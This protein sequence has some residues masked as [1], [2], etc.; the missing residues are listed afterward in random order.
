MSY[1]DW[2]IRRAAPEKG[3]SSRTLIPDFDALSRQTAL[4]DK[5]R[6]A[7]SQTL[8]A[9][10]AFEYSRPE[11]RTPS[12]GVQI[13]RDFGHY[14]GRKTP[15]ASTRPQS[16]RQS[17]YD[18]G[19][20]FPQS[21]RTMASERRP[22]SETEGPQ[23]NPSRVTPRAENLG[24]QV[25]AVSAAGYLEL[26]KRLQVRSAIYRH[27]LCDHRHLHD[28]WSHQET[29]EAMQ[30]YD[31]TEEVGKLQDQLIALI[32]DKNGLQERLK[33]RCLASF[34][35]QHSNPFTAAS[36]RMVCV[37][38]L[39]IIFVLIPPDRWSLNLPRTRN[40]P[41]PYHRS[42]LQNLTAPRSILL[43]DFSLFCIL[44]FPLS[45]STCFSSR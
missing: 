41:H 7:G 16:E 11:Q 23:Y 39:S 3:R 17:N 37:S 15:E 21:P 20:Q 27:K 29:T 12:D 18:Y 22:Y 44:S 13:N 34:I 5:L 32:K 19:S 28:T 6:R 4:E 31:A 9:S 14:V 35:S 42:N 45:H 10:S 24:F 2:N 38:T 40:N 30:R 36:W 8:A 43:S 33:V 1:G 26:T 25:P